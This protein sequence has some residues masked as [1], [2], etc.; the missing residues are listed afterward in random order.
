MEIT[1]RSDEGLKIQ[2]KNNRGTATLEIEP[3]SINTSVRLKARLQNITDTN[4]PAVTLAGDG[5]IE[6]SVVDADTN[7]S[8]ASSSIIK[9]FIVGLDDAVQVGQKK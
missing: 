6:V 2:I 9:D 5:V 4:D 7:L 8:I 1:A 3:D